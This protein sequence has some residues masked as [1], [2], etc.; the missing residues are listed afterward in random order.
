MK[1]KVKGK[2]YYVFECPDLG[3]RPCKGASCIAY[4]DGVC[5]KY[6]RRVSVELSPNHRLQGG[7]FDVGYRWLEVAGIS[8]ESGE[9]RRGNRGQVKALALKGVKSLFKL[10]GRLRHA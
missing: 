6:N 4:R 8:E 7:E 5:M 9:E 2:Q 10:A 1:V 3:G